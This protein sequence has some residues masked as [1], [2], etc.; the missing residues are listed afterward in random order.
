MTSNKV[1]QIIA[2]GGGKG[3]TGKSFLSSNIGAYLASIG[4]KVILI[5]A[6][7]GGANL[8]SFL[9]LPTNKKTISDFIE[10]NIPLKDTVYP[11]K[12][13]NL[14]MIIGD[15]N[16]FNSSNIKY[17]QKLKLYRHI[18][19]LDAEYILLDLGAGAHYNT[20]DSFLIADKMVVVVTPEK[21]SIE[22]MYHFIKNSLIRNIEK[23]YSFHNKKYE[24]IQ[25]YKDKEKLGIKNIKELIDYLIL[26][27]KTGE[28]LAADIRDFKLCIIINKVKNIKNVHIGFSIQSV[29]NKYLGIN[30]NFIGFVEYDEQVSASTNNNEIL[31][32]DYPA[33]RLVKEIKQL[34]ENL[35][36]DKQFK[37]R[38]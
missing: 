4:H 8:H 28:R 10:N 5:D 23:I 27:T 19:N 12:V 29:L 30:T 3:G 6:D 35:I 2:V 15:I 25:I 26:N 36:Q 16:S 38:L 14:N 17:T 21:I 1:K 37:I 31:V 32:I 34:S 7:L 20:I 33:L 9:N 13:K 24:F 11:T 18:M 22:N